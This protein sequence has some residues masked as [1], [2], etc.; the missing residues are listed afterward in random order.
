MEKYK[1]LIVGMG[2]GGLYAEVYKEMGHDVVTVDSDP[3]KGATYKSVD[4]IP[5]DMRFS[6]ANICTPNFTHETVARA[7]ATKCKVVIIEKPGVKNKIEWERLC[8]DFPHTRFMMTKNNQYRANISE[9]TAMYDSAKTVKLHWINNNR[10]PNAGTWFTTK[11]LAYG[12]VSRDLL[13][14]L[15][16]LYIQF[17]SE[18]GYTEWT[19]TQAKQNWQL[20]EL[21][22]TDYG[23]VKQDGVY[24]V[25]DYVKLT[26]TTGG[27]DWEI[28]AD[29][30]SNSSDDIGIYFDDKFVPLGMCPVEAYR[31]MVTTVIANYNNPK[32]WQIQFLQDVWIHSTIA[33]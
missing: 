3:A 31:R 4:D 1:H 21:S 27:K 17:E 32:F 11:E 13:P 18:W 8:L 25:D 2:F 26:T 9:M 30:K 7:I 28:I 23:T 12:G 19:S 33:I 20:S 15:L 5:A 22:T 29:W 24:D 16:S 10:V 6:I 14:H